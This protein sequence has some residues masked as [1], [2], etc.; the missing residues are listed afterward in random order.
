VRFL[1]EADGGLLRGPG[2]DPGVSFRSEATP[3]SDTWET[4]PLELEL[5]ASAADFLGLRV[6]IWAGD[7]ALVQASTRLA[8]RALD[9]P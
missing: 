8:V 9:A 3:F 2:C 6:S 4:R 1:V 7:Q 5:V